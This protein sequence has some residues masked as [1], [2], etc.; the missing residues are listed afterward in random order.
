ML[1]IL[2]DPG[3]CEIHSFDQRLDKFGGHAPEGI[4]LHPW[5]LEGTAD[6]K[7]SRRNYM[8]LK[9]TV[10]HLG[11]QGR[12]LDIMRLDCE[13]CEWNT[14]REWLGTEISIG[15]IVVS[16]HGAPKNEDGIF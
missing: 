12:E 10:Q 1:K 5:G 3:S 16:L 2:G 13:G 8:T 15:Q 9:E 11:H 14:F 6:A 7:L 4:G